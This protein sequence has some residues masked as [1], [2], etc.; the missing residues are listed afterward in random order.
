[1]S[2]IKEKN[3]K[4]LKRKS[5]WPSI[6]LFLTFM[7]VSVVV[8]F[9]G[10]NLFTTYIIGVKLT[11]LHDQAME[12]GIL[13][14]RSIQQGEKITYAVSNVERYRRDPSDVY[15]TDEQGNWVM[16][17]GSSE[18]LF[19]QS[20][21]WTLGER[22]K[23]YKDSAW[24][25]GQGALDDIESIFE[26]HVPALAHRA[27][28]QAPDLRGSEAKRA[29]WMQEPII[30]Q[31]FWMY[32]PVSLNGKKLYVKCTLQIIRQDVIYIMILGAIALVLLFVPL[33]FL[34]INT[35][36]N[37]RMQ[38]RVTKLLYMDP[39]TGGN[40]WLYFQG[41]AAKV[42][43]SGWN[44]RKT[45]AIVDL[46]M[47]RYTNYLSCYG[48]KQGEELLECM[49]GFLRARMKRKEVFGHYGKA[50]FGLIL[51]CEGA[52]EEACRQNCYRRLRSLLAELAGLQPE[53]KLH[54]HAG[55]CMVLPVNATEGSWY[56]KR[57]N[58]DI[59][60]LFSFANTAQASGHNEAEQIFF[61]SDRL[62]EEQ[63][64]E[65]WV[66]S[67]MQSALAAGEFQVY[68]QPKYTPTGGRLVGAEALVRWICPEKGMIPPGRFIPLFEENGFIMKL[69]DYMLSQIA[70]LQAEWKV[71][72]KKTVPISVNISR[73]H[74]TQEGL[75][76]H[77]SQLVDSYGPKHKLIEL[78]VTESAFFDD[79]DV[80][81]NTVKQLRAYDFPISMDDFGAGYSSL[82][83]LK[84]IP[85]D[86]LKL[87]AEFFR[88]EDETGRGAIIVR[89]AICLA[90]ELNMRVVAEGIEQKE[91]VD[92]LAGLGCD[93]IQGF[94]FAKPMPVAEFEARMAADA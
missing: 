56:E 22:C 13:M 68:L 63:S 40:N 23:V 30:E 6:L 73:A 17:T 3:L 29:R 54:F 89:E 76:E 12:T 87:D 90:R 43:G 71:Q 35:I 20:F 51:Q 94:Y 86:V 58:V 18:P 85:L 21:E 91:Q 55:V 34:F 74:F 82:N 84:D 83:T 7:A 37:I 25:Y 92:F 19:D 70:K 15:V 93:M 33:L 28:H 42:L 69:D 65:Q 1:M 48:S 8:I 59:D 45:Y 64:W 41:Y 77:I 32:V 5:F 2:K 79:K 16:S 75:A 26:L 11:S 47:E 9:A 50:D 49:D 80:L 52:N 38:H 31:Q 66:E 62:L 4:K 46:H 53:R 24:D 57:K 60:Q 78:E 44:S 72:G 10:I 67:N 36:L 61:F 81:V 88:G 27:F 14:E 39:V